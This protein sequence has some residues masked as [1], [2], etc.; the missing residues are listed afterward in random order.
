M[1]KDR[2]KQIDEVVRAFEEL[3]ERERKEHAKQGESTRKVKPE[4]RNHK[5]RGESESKAKLISTL[6]HKTFFRFY[7]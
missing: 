7:L 4:F 2:R 3:Q 1:K 5:V 6:I